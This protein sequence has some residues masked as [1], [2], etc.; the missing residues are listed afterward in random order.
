M[1]KSEWKAYAA[2]FVWP[3]IVLT[4]AAVAVCVGVSRQR[5]SDAGPPAQLQAR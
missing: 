5:E 3:L 1:W 2:W 4:L